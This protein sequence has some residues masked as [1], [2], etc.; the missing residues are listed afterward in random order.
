MLLFFLGSSLLAFGQS[1]HVGVA[2]ADQSSPPTQ[3]RPSTIKNAQP[4]ELKQELDA[5]VIALSKIPADPLIKPD[6]VAPILRP[7]DRLVDSS[8]D[9]L[10]LKFG[11]TYTFLNQYATITPDGV[12]HNQTSGRLDFTGAWSV[13]DHESTAGSISLLVRSGTNIGYSQ[14][15][16]L[17]DR[18]GS[19]LY[20][21][22]LQGGGPQEPITL[23]VLYWR[24]DFFAKRL[25]FYVGKIHPNEYITL[26]MFNNDERSQFLNGAN[27]GND[28]V[29]D[30]GT[31]AGGAAVE[32]QAT[33]HVYIHAVAVDTEGA[34]QRNIETLVDRKYME[35]VELGWSSGSVGEKYR[36]YR[37]GMWRDDTKNMGSGYGGGFEFDHELSNGWTPFGRV[38][39]GTNKGTAIKDQYGIGLAQVHPFG[40]RGDMFGAAFNYTQPN[41]PGKHHESV[42][43]SFYRLR[44]TQ[45]VEIGPDLEVSIHPTYA[46]KAYTTTLLGARIRIIF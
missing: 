8:I 22:C 38:V 39:F 21:N 45:S 28:A 7:V 10:R 26:S 29:A 43:E 46:T 20:L 1:N 37:I 35:G 19:G 13:Y 44:L 40:R 36:L 23:N 4:D 5:D 11:A 32:F 27:D 30:D 17:N 34:Q 33:R 14:Q 15:W 9:S 42:F 2:L 3:G 31:Y 24:Q 12:R 6:P 25:S 16:N 18:L 41:F